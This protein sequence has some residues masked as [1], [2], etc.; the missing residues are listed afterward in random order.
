MD[1]RPAGRAA[2][3]QARPRHL[4]APVSPLRARP[5]ARGQDAGAH[6]G[7]AAEAGAGPGGAAPRPG[8][9]AAPREPA[10]PAARGAAGLREP[11]EPAPARASQPRPPGAARRHRRR[12]H[13][14]PLAVASSPLSGYSIHLG[15][16]QLAPRLRLDPSRR[17]LRR[18]R[19]A[20]LARCP[21][22]ARGNGA[23]PLGESRA[24][25][26]APPR[27]ARPARPAPA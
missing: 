24:A 18:L 15:L 3:D 4:P 8:H 6:A 7:V 21:R 14:L 2:W 5:G 25:P 12:R 13:F 19:S 17:R 22:T 23:Q 10:S 27:S 11:S 16:E 9:K 26:A 1:A 20:Q